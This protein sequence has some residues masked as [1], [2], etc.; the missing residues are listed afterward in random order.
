MEDDGNGQ[1]EE[2]ERSLLIQFSPSA[3]PKIG[4]D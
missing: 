4:C 1:S 2:D 3:T